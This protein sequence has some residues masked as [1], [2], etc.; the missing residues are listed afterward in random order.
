MYIA[1]SKR[2]LS[3]AAHD[4]RMILTGWLKRAGRKNNLSP[5][6]QHLQFVQL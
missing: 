5:G 1:D 6:T 3:V 2:R 4:H